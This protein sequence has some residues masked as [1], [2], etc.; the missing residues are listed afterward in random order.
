MLSRKALLSRSRVLVIS[1]PPN[2]EIG[3][4]VTRI[5]KGAIRLRYIVL[6]G[7]LAGGYQLNK[8]YEDW[9]EKVPDMTWLTEM[10]PESEKLD[11]F[12][13]SLIHIKHNLGDMIGSSGFSSWLNQ[14][15][16]NARRAAIEDE[17]ARST[18][19]L[20]SALDLASSDD[21]PLVAQEGQTGEF[22][23]A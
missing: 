7:G 3:M 12:R 15:L 10:M 9:K 20:D 19:Q 14:R 17:E 5:I 16:E 8:T 22:T 13:A 11:N 2:R 18:L 4:L 6:G 21:D 23:P 1:R